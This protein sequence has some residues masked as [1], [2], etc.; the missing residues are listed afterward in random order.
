ME[1]NSHFKA[2]LRLTYGTYIPEYTA[3]LLVK[4]TSDY[5]R[6]TAEGAQRKEKP[7]WLLPGIAIYKNKNLQG[8]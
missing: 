8:M 6:N 4:H 2:V 7:P 3:Q 1:V 5:N